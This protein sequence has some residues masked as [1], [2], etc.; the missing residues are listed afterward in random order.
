MGIDYATDGPLAVITIN[1]PEAMNSF[2]PGHNDALAAAYD[3]FRADDAV[4]C[5]ILTGVGRAF[6]A[7]ADLKKLM[8]TLRAVALDEDGGPWGLGGMTWS[9]ETE[10]PMIAAINGH[11]LAGGLELALACDIRVCVPAATFGLAEVKWAII[12]GGG[13]TQRLPRAIPLG[14]AMEMIL[15]GD[16]IDADTALRHGLV[17]RV[18]QP[19]ELMNEAL[20]IARA[21][22]RRGPVAV[23][24]AKQAVHSGLQVDLESG[25]KLEQRLLSECMRTGDAEEGPRAFAEKRD[26][27][28]LGR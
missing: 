2:D 4:R 26:P 18:V 3:R 27:V 21:I 10:K 19:E 20:R 5:G 13:G 14:I 1:R 9:P 7:G 12:P 11:A 24:A 8:P 25:L 15:T 16:P 28:Y 23:R 6:S 22:T 17:S